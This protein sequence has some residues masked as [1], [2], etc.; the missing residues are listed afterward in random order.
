MPSIYSTSLENR[1]SYTSWC[2]PQ[3][4]PKFTNSSLHKSMTTT[5]PEPKMIIYCW[6]IYYYTFDCWWVEERKNKDNKAKNTKIRLPSRSYLTLSHWKS[7]KKCRSE[8]SVNVAQIKYPGNCNIT[9]TK[10]WPNPVA[11]LSAIRKMFSEH[12]W[13]HVSLAHRHWKCALSV[14]IL[15]AKSKHKWDWLKNNRKG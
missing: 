6:I 13:L 5:C 2:N 14:L 1:A 11:A 7:I 9:S 15:K 12:I 8:G 10:E 3:T 4:I